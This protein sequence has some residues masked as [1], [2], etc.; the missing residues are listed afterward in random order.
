MQQF[1]NLTLII[2]AGGK[3]SRMGTDKALLKYQGKTFV[4][5]L[6]NNIKGICSEVIISS[7]NP[8]VRV[9]GSKTVTDDIQEIGPMGGLYTCLKQSNTDF[10]LVVSVDTPFVSAKLLT[11]VYKQSQK[12]DISIIEHNKKLHPL[13]GVYHKNV[14]KILKSE[15]KSEKYKVIRFLKKTKYQVISVENSYKKELLNINNSE[16]YKKLLEEH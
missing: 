8:E 2:L 12:Y 3:S 15:I 14:V 6:Y 1:N 11:K 5:I 10:N 4:Q 13:I 7:N 16:D 9:E